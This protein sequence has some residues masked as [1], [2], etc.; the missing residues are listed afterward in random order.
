MDSDFNELSGKS[1]RDVYKMDK[2]LTVKIDGDEYKLSDI[3]NM[4]ERLKDKFKN[5]SKIPETLTDIHDLYF[6]LTQGHEWF[7]LSDKDCVRAGIGWKHIY[8]DDEA[9]F[10]KIKTSL[11]HGKIENFNMKM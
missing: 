6:I 11:C 5:I 7:H 9:I 4:I 3:L 1:V 8:D 2:E 10:P